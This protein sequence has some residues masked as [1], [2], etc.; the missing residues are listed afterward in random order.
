MVAGMVKDLRIVFVGS[1]GSTPGAAPTSHHGSDRVARTPGA[2]HAIGIPMDVV[3]RNLA[4]YAWAREQRDAIIGRAD[5]WLRYDDTRLR[6]LVPPPEVPRAVVAHVKGAPVNGEALNRIGRYSWILSFEEP[7]KVTS[8]VDGRTYPSNDFGAF[9]VSG[10]KDRSLL[11]GPLPDDGWGCHVEGEDKPFWFV[12]VYAHWSVRNLLLPALDDLSRAYVITADRRYA[13]ACCV[14]LWQ[15]AEYYPR[16]FY[17]KQSRYGREITPDYKGRLLYHTWESNN[18]CRVVPPAYGL[19]RPAIEGDD[20][21]AELTGQTA[22]QIRAHIEDRMLRTMAGDI[23]DGS[24]RIQGNYSMHQRSLLLIAEVLR[25]SRRRPTSR[26][27][28]E[29]VLRNPQAESYFQ[30]GMVDALNNLLYRDGYPNESP[31]YNVAWIQGLSDMVQALGREGRSIISMGRFRK[32]FAWPIRMACAGEFVPSYGDSGDLFHRLL[33]WT[34][35]VFEPAYRVWKDPIYAKALEHADTE[36]TRDLFRDPVDEEELA[37]AVAKAPDRLGVTGELLPGVGFAS[38]QTGCE[39]NRTAL[40]VF[41]GIYWG[42]AHCDRLQLDL[43]SWGNVLT[44]DLGYPETADAHDPRRG[45]F[46]SHTVTHNTVMV[47]AGRQALARGRLHIYDPGDSV[48]LVETSAEAC[49]PDTVSLYRRTLMLVDVAPD[50]AYVVDIFRVRGGTQHDWIVHGTQADFDSDLPLSKPSQK[51]T[52]AGPEVAYGHFYDDERYDN[53]NEARVPYHL[54]EGSAFQWLFNAQE[55]RLNGVGTASWHLNRPADLYPHRECEGLVL[56]AHLVGMDETVIACDGVPQRRET[57]PDTLKFVLRRRVGEELESVYVTVFEPYRDAPFI[58]S[59]RPIPLAAGADLPV[60]LEISSHESTHI[61]FSRLEDAGRGGSVLK[62]DDG[63]IVDARAAVLERTDTGHWAHTYRLDGGDP[64]TA[65][66]AVVESVDYERGV[67][68]LDRPVLGDAP[69]AGG[70][71]MVESR[72]HADAISVA[73][74]IDART[75]AVGDEDLSA[76]T[77]HVTS[78]RGNRIRFLPEHVWF[79]QPGMTVVDEADTVVGRVEVVEQGAARLAGGPLS[80][81][82]FPDRDGDGQRTCRAMVVGPGDRVTLHRSV[83]A[84]AHGMA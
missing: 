77:V 35:E 65:A 51:G 34:S 11:T 42:H 30:M 23:M 54:Y 44:P 19:V 8:P 20:A 64:A 69:P 49:Y 16:Y 53:D 72:S 78:A 17:E 79:I 29:Y 22:S 59:V 5:A 13:H 27:M 76:G 10:L 37:E 9:L 84:D 68:T 14:L 45:G 18:T 50:K 62:L 26:Q 2:P 63:T 70:V 40:A 81:R 43:Y 52:V 4:R 24:D 82:R 31:G 74:I 56:R 38:L 46:I 47:N 15:L 55:A 61:L 71:A 75:F 39:A 66:G 48:Q 6:T 28:R 32:L 21:L 58:D 25:A 7:W 12:G 36:H 33:G 80:L 41:Y 60:A 1:E 73:T 83:R 57:W 67:V 3:S